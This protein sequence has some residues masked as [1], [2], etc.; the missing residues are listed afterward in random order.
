MKFV[1]TGDLHIGKIVNG[2]SM[3]EDQRYILKQVYEISRREKA[4]ALVLA[5]D[6]YDRAIPPADAVVLFND[7]LTDMGKGRDSPFL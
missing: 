5:G 6:I 2:F 1:H 3:I 4:D 7:F